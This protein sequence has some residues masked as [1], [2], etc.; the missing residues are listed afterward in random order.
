MRT[1]DNAKIIETIEKQAF[2][3]YLEKLS[4]TEMHKITLFTRFPITATPN[5]SNPVYFLLVDDLTK[6]ADMNSGVYGN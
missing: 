4:H 6:I 3:N 1:M 5:L 2:I